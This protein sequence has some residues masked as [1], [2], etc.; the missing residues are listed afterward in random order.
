[1]WSLLGIWIAFIDNDVN[2]GKTA[3][4]ARPRVKIDRNCPASS[5]T[6]SPATVIHRK[7]SRWECQGSKGLELSEVLL[8]VVSPFES[9]VVP[10][11]LLIVVLE[12]VLLKI[13]KLKFV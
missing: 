6:P 10:V 12:I 13:V 8:L 2:V 3:I 9:F 7:H 5:D 4:A 11:V 1:M